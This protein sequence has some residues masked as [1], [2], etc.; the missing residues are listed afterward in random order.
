LVVNKKIYAIE[1]KSSLQPRSK[2]FSGLMAF[3]EEFPQA[4]LMMVTHSSHSSIQNSVDVLSVPDF[5]DWL[6]LKLGG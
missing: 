5:V 4:H 3:K 2:D 1:V 6:W